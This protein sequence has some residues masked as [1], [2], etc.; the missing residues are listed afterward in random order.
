MSYLT[1]IIGKSNFELV[2]SKIAS[3]LADELANQ[4]TLNQT[5]L[6]TEE[7]ADTIELLNLNIDSIPDRVWE[8]RFK[9]PQKEEY[10]VTPLVN[11]LFAQSP[12][13]SQSVSTQIG[14]NTFMVEF[15]VGSREPGTDQNNEGDSLASIK[16]QRIMW[17][18]RSIL[19]YPKY[20][21]L[22][23]GNY[24]GSVSVNNIQVSQP[25]YGNDNAANLIYGRFNVTIKISE[26]VEAVTGETLEQSYTESTI[27]TLDTENGY[28]WTLNN[29]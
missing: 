24:V 3:I 14:D 2:R 20:N 16:L 19:M 29:E 11:V 23:L 21:R 4:K 22:D 27:K 12:L 17:I 25:D 13:D 5:A 18:C 8:E 10:Q 28:Y 7:D 1:E 15:Y 9:R 26:T 6:E